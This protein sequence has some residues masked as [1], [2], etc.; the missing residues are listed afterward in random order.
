MA[1]KAAEAKRTPAG[2]P[3]PAAASLSREAE[4]AGIPRLSIPGVVHL[5]AAA[6]SDPIRGLLGRRS[7]QREH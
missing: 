1:R 7:R 4:G 3:Q 5:E 2:E 6:R